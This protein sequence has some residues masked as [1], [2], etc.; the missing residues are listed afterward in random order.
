MDSESIH[1]KRG[2]WYKIKIIGSLINL[3]LNNKFNA[4]ESL[5]R[6]RFQ[7]MKKIE[8]RTL[9]KEEYNFLRKKETPE[10]YKLIKKH[11]IK[12]L[13]GLSLYLQ[14]IP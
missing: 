7:A 14:N 11:Q 10:I 2:H 12:S 5:E 9:L 1:P 3:S 13:E 4:L 6:I 8:N